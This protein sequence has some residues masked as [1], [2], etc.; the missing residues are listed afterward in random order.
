MGHLSWSSNLSVVKLHAQDARA[1][2][3]QPWRNRSAEATIL[4]TMGAVR[5]FP[6]HRG[7]PTEN[8]H[9]PPGMTWALCPSSMKNPCDMKPLGT[10]HLGPSSWE[11]CLVRPPLYVAAVVLEPSW[12]E[13]ILIFLG[14]IA[15]V[16]T[17]K[18]DN[19]SLNH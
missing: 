2:A 16:R 1:H 10:K 14:K 3:T 7:L 8:D 5:G 18:R 4:S 19:Q 6:K 17:W 11:W 9:G 12:F 13:S 15:Q